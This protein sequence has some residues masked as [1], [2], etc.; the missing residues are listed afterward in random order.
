[1]PAPV[2]T[3]CLAAGGS[4]SVRGA[5]FKTALYSLIVGQNLVPLKPTVQLSS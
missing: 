1:M 2:V 5:L 3:T 4:L